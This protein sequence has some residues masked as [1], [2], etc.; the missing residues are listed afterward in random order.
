LPVE[1]QNFVLVRRRS[2]LWV[3]AGIVFVHVPKAAG[4]SINQALYGRFMG[5]IP[6]SSIHRWGSHEVRTL[7]SFAVCRNPWDRLV[8]AYRFVKQ[9]GGIGGPFTAGVWR[10]ELY[11]GP[12]FESF[13]R[14]V[15]EWLDGRDIGSLEYH[16]HAQTHYV[17]DQSGRILVNHLGRYENLAPTIA[18]LEDTVG[19]MPELKRW[20]RSGEA[21]DYRSFYTP[22]L[23][24]IVGRIY[25][26]DVRILDYSFDG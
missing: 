2:P 26:D 23:I 10:P 17:C 21:V 18:F 7:P 13:E 25:A 6:A 4:T 3:R 19:H 8:S 24:E 9:G 11:R 12:E 15:I 5:H 22:E 16:F 20:N 14:F 1:L